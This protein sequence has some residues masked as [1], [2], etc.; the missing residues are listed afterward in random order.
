MAKKILSNFLSKIDDLDEGY[1]NFMIK[2]VTLIVSIL[3]FYMIYINILQSTETTYKDYIIILIALIILGM[4]ISYMIYINRLQNRECNHMNSIYPTVNGNIV[5]IKS[6]DQNCRGKL[7]DY[8]IKTAYNACS[9]GSYKNDYVNICHLKTV[10]KQ[11]VR[12]LDFEIYSVDDKAV[13]ATSTLD[14]YHVKETFNSVNFGSVMDTIRNYAFA[15]STCP[16]PTDPLIIHLRCK[17]NN[18][19]M[20]TNLANIFR[21]NT[22]I[23]LGPK[24]SFESAGANLGNVPL[25]S[26]QNKV[27]VI[28]DKTNEAFIENNKLLEYV[29][30]TSN[31]LYMRK[32][33]YYNIKNNSDSN[34]LSDFNRQGMTI[35]IPNKGSNP[36]N[37]SGEVCR[38]S[39]CQMIAMRYQFVDE[40]LKK[41]IL[42]FD[43]AGYAFA[44]KPKELR[45]K[46]VAVKPPT[47][48][49]L[50]TC[51]VRPPA[52][53]VKTSTAEVKTPTA[54]VKTPTDDKTTTNDNSF[55]AYQDNMISRFGF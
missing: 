25:L 22:D 9:G 19:S 46:L 29:N 30:L 11:G 37:P 4:F 18:Q 34:E 21:S 52:C 51:E 40:N 8:Y 43:R 20:Y 2:V 50:P 6:S 7:F 12:C 49:K 38:E 15:S 36:T 27:I 53:E 28:M 14:N 24:Y 47:E 31:S 10:I 41:N 16:N 45:D 55:T 26:L 1:Y 39:G 48:A 42:F 32:Y 33:D 35:V 44:L 23:M 17:S 13:V 3:I 5:P 54:E